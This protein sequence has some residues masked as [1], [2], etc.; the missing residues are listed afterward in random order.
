MLGEP[1]QLL[2]A[3]FDAAIG[4]ASP[5][6]RIPALSSPAA[7]GAHCRHRRGKGVGCDGKG[8]RRSL[9]RPADRTCR[10]AIRPRRTSIFD[11][12]PLVVSQGIASHWSAPESADLPGITHFA[13]WESPK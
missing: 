1:R 8:G 6:L 4:A 2:K 5:K 11:P 10:D 9:A 3:M 12:V 13:P 7:E